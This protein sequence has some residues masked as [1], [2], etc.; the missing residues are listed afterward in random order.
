[1]EVRFTVRAENDILESYVYGME[2]FGRPQAERYEQGL[3]EA[4]ARIADFPGLAPERPDFVPPIRLHHHG[5][6]AI[7][8]LIQSD[9]ILI[10]RVLRGQRDIGHHLGSEE[11]VAAD[12]GFSPPRDQ[13]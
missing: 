1:M 7:I 3:R 10:V 11:R 2:R 5:S 12:A 8:Y 6:H 13:P 4:I 9:H